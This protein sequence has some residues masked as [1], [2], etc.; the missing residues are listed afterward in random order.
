MD[1]ALL[2]TI[3]AEVDEINKMLDILEAKNKLKIP[4][5]LKK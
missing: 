2:A 5:T 1:P 4:F 3:N